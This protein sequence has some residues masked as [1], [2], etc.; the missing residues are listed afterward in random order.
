MY[1][2]RISHFCRNEK[3]RWY[4]SPLCSCCSERHYKDGKILHLSLT[5]DEVKERNEERRNKML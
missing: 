3:W 2:R 5:D 1:E 4:A